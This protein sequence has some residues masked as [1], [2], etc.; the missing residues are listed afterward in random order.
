M[1][2]QEQKKVTDYCLALQPIC[3]QH[4]RHVG[5]ELLYR[6]SVNAR[7][8]VIDNPLV[9]TARVC[10]IAFYEMGREALSGPR[11][12]FFNTPR[13]WL[14]NPDLLPPVADRIVLE[15]LESVE[16]DAEVIAAL[17]NIKALG[18]RIALDDFVLNKATS[19]LLALADIVKIDL[20]NNGINEQELEL[21]KSYGIQ[22]LA[23][24]VEDFDTF[25]RCRDLDFTLFQGYF[26]ARPEVR[27]SQFIKRSSNK[28][29]QLRLLAVL[30][31]REPEYDKLESLMAQDSP[32]CIRLLRLC[33]SPLYR[34]QCEISSLR[35]AMIL[36]GFSGLRKLIIVIL[37]A[38][39]NPC[40]L[41]LLPKALTRAAMC[42]RLAEESQHDHP[43]SA[44][45]VGILSMMDTLLDEPLDKLCLQLPL[46]EAVRE[47][48][49]KQQGRLGEILRLTIAYE[50]A[51]LGSASQVVVQRLN[52]CYMNSVSW[53]NNLLIEVADT[54]K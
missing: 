43:D 35:Q 11:E 44:F 17:R 8:A 45:L 5:D 46:S 18:Y 51:R 3:D 38:D 41:L 42:E 32:L 37:L 12:L 28:A 14:V 26:Y 34:R 6:A 19:P 9:A 2:E 10:N 1:P 20:L 24:K 7:A 23:E 48:L 50:D 15:V 53:A 29:A 36:V 52:R 4:L 21:Y 40:N 54:D 39:N 25:K 49:L 33:N 22:L 27:Q 30:N 31:E 47:A 13:E 16:G